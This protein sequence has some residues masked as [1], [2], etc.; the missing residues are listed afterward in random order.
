MPRMFSPSL[1]Y[2]AS[3]V[4]LAA[5]LN[6]TPGGAHGDK[7]LENAS[8]P[9]LILGVLEFPNSG[10]AEAQEAFERGVLLLHSFEYDDARAA[11]LEAQS[12][13]PGFAMAIWGEAMTH[14]HPL[15]AQQ[16]RAAALA[17]LAK[18]PP[19][20]ERSA[21]AREQMY[22]DA[23]AALY[24]EGDKPARD[25]AYRQAMRGIHEAYPDDLEAASFYALSM[26]GSVYERDF[27]TYMQA[28]SILEEVF[29]RQPRHPGAAHYLIHSYDD[30]VHA[31]LGLRA[32]REYAQIAPNAS[33][34]QHMVSHIYTSL[35]MWEEVVAANRT[36]VRVSEEAMARTGRPV[37]LRNKHS[38]HWLEYALL[39]QGRMEE[40]G[41]TLRTMRDDLAAQPNLNHKN[42]H[43]M[44]RASWVVEAPLDD[45]PLGPLD[46]QGMPLDMVAVDRFASGFRAVSLGNLDEARAELEA[47]RRAIGTAV[48]VGV[49]QGLHEDD[50]ATSEDAH[51][52]ASVM[53]DE[54]EALV[55]YRSG[56]DA[57]ALSLLES[58]AAVENARPLEYGPPYIPKPCSELLGEMLLK[59][60]RPADAVPH[61]ADSLARNTARTASLLGLARAREAAGDADGAAEAWQGVRDNWKGDVSLLQ[62]SGYPWLE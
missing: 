49:G 57:D 44:I 56:A 27:R 58:A 32:A 45:M 7:P 48:V 24:G 25:M 17:T 40:A 61:F 41:E 4:A 16:D 8:G 62:A 19:A 34:A 2:L 60:G 53:A 12:R 30:Q 55:L 37:A 20:D 52:V 15:W 26:L 36:A 59:L 50:S 5:A 18:L 29:A 42:H 23:V 39:Q 10:A 38:L 28:A 1:R 51:R 47:L 9:P 21:T 11:F 33:H 46:Y 6:A 3:A 22:L 14:N 13:D 43:A 35:G 54:L 31:P